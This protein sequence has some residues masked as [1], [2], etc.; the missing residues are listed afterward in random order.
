[1]DSNTLNVL[2][3]IFRQNPRKFT[4][5]CQDLNVGLIKE[6]KF[7]VLHIQIHSRIVEGV[8]VSNA[9]ALL[10]YKYCGADIEVLF[11]LK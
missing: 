8:T 3:K 2:Q 10:G 6:R 1:M 9:H 7:S 4:V 11:S 5:L